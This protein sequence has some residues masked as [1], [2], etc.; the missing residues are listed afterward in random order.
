MSF[1]N[2]YWS[3][4][5]ILKYKDKG[6]IGVIKSIFNFLNKTLNHKHT[7]EFPLKHYFIKKEN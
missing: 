1:F 4:R 6:L 2:S 7:G 5:I 3:N